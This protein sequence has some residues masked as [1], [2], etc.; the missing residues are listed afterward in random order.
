MNQHF[1]FRFNVVTGRVEYRKKG[2]K[3]FEVL[4]E[5][6]LNSIYRGVRYS[7]IEI[8]LN[9]LASLLASEFSVRYDPFRDY[10]DSL[11]A[12]MVRQTTSHSLHR[13]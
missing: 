2:E 3:C 4:Q 7:H 10:F 6:D 9:T 5:Y 12:W 13:P 8:G 11:P 1:D